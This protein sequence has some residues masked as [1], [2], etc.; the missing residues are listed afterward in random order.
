MA[1]K[2]IAS[3]VG[4]TFYFENCGKFIITKD[5]GKSKSGH[6]LVEIKFLDTNTT[7]VVEYYNAVYGKVKDPN[8]IIYDLKDNIYHCIEGGD[9]KIIENL[10]T[11]QGKKCRMVKIQFLD[12]GYI[13]EV[14][15]G[16]ALSGNVKDPTRFMYDVKNKIFTS[17]HYGKYKII[18][19]LGVIDGSCKVRIKFLDT[20][21]ESI[22]NRTHALNGQ[23]RDA[24]YPSITKAIENVGINPIQDDNIDIFLRPIWVGIKNRCDNKNYP[25]FK[26]YGERGVTYSESWNIYENFKFDVMHIPGWIDKSLNPYNFHLDKDLLQYDLPYNMRVYSRNTCIWLPANINSTIANSINHNVH[27]YYN[28]IYEVFNIYFIKNPDPN[29]F[30]Y[31][32]FFDYIH[33]IRLA[34]E[35]FGFI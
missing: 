5:L 27:I 4:E 33:T 13:S 17:N 22:V 8:K 30:S 19:N 16:H 20:G 29:C 10:G 26:L 3:H 12:T 18:E 6:I 14:Q 2:H 31:G 34:N 32:P 7:K 11:P 28:Y 1:K 15:F 9:Y 35:Y 21:Y 23:V 24:T 25:S